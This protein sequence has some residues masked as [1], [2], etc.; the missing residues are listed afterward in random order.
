MEVIK[1]QKDCCDYE[2]HLNPSG[3]SKV[4]AFLG[5]WLTQRYALED[6]RGDRAYAYW[7][8]NLQKYE[9][10]RAEVWAD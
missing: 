1:N 5:E 3:A 10:H 7:D 8:E 4:T 6:R 9:A 2:G